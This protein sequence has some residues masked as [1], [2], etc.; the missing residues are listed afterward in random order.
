MSCLVRAQRACDDRFELIRLNHNHG[1][2]GAL[3]VGTRAADNDLILFLDADLMQLLPEHIPLLIDPVRRSECDMT[4]GIFHHG[5]WQTDLTHRCFPF[6]SGQR[7]VRWPLFQTLFADEPLRW[8]VETAFNLHAWYHRYPVQHVPWWGVMHATRAEK[9]E[10]VSGYWSH[11][12]MW[13]QIGTYALRFLLSQGW[14]P[15]ATPAKRQSDFKPL[16]SSD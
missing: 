11:V 15:K 5:R 9:Q 6:L 3:F 12:K 8:S 10:G 16:A 7:C 2:G 1:K 13:G 14:Q 4:L